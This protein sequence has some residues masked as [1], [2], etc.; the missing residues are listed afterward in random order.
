MTKNALRKR[1]VFTFLNVEKVLHFLMVNGMFF[2][3]VAGAFLK[4]VLPCVTP[5]T[6]G[7]VIS[8]SDSDLRDL[9]G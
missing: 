3:R 9:F 8:G 1:L 6:F 7:V 5:C 2:H 4:H